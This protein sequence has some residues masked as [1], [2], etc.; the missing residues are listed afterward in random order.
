[1]LSKTSIVR[2]YLI[3]E[4]LQL[5]ESSELELYMILS[6]MS[7]IRKRIWLCFGLAVKL[8]PT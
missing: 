5:R 2:I 7:L 8:V 3:L 4:L 1:M 6:Y